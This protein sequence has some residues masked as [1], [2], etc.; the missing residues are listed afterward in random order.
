MGWGI[1]S[2][3]PLGH[4]T[5]GGIPATAEYPPGLC[6]HRRGSEFPPGTYLSAS[7]GISP[8]RQPVA[9]FILKLTVTEGII[10]KRKTAVVFIEK[11]TDYSEATNMGLS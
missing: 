9:K 2:A 11:A 1:S 7:P 8:V 6:I 3:H 5:D 4:L 10:K